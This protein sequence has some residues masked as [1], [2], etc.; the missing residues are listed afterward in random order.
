[1]GPEDY[2]LWGTIFQK[3]MNR[4]TSTSLGIK[5]SIYLEWEKK[6]QQNYRNHEDSVSFLLRFL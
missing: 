5:G 6:S 4:I 1:M 2:A 3:Q